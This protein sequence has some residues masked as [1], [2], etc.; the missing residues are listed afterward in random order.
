LLDDVQ[1]PIPPAS[2]AAARL[3]ALRSFHYAQTGKLNEA[4]QAAHVARAIQEQ[5]QLSDEWNVIV[6][7]M[8]L[9]IYPY[10]GEYEAVEREA[11][12]AVEIP[13]LT[14][15]ARLVLVPGAQAI[16][17]FEAGLLPEAADAARAAEADARRLGFDQHFFA[18][19]GLRVLAGLALE[20]RA[21]DTAERLVEQALSITERRRPIFEFVLLLDRAAIWAARGQ[22][23]EALATVKAARVLLPGA[24]SALLSRADEL[25]ALLRLSLGDVRSP[26]ELASGLCAPRRGLLMAKIALTVGDHHAA[27]E[28]LQALP[29]ADLT[30]RRELVRQ[31]LLAAAAMER[32][33]PSA[34]GI[35]GG[36][37]QTARRGGFLNTVVTAAPQVTRYLM[38]DSAQ[39]RA[40]PFMERLAAAALEVRVAEPVGSR[41]SLALAEPLTAAELRILKLLPTSTYLQ[42]A[43]TLYISRNTVKTH[44]RSIYQKLG[45]TSRSAAIERAVDLRLL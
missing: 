19:D 2:K 35:L 16:A 6:P 20:R 4:V 11:A 12:A 21:L 37:L 1:P 7:L 28:H 32:G 25:E 9:R 27:Q 41:S 15:S 26:T 24:D 45:V 18:V 30:P 36:A 38:D 14:E 34:V 31:I 10:L 8:L 22:V 40:D 17:W 42:I 29:R 13:E 5:T 43:A 33:D 39:A 23:R 44:L 3:V